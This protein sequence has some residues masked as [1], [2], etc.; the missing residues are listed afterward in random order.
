MLLS[1][2]LTGYSQREL[3]TCNSD[4]TDAYISFEDLKD[5]SNI[6]WLKEQNTLSN[7][8][9]E[10]L[11][12]FTDHLKEKK[13]NN[14]DRYITN[15]SRET[16]TREGHIFYLKSTKENQK[17]LYYI[18]NKGE[19]HIKLVDLNDLPF[20]NKISEGSYLTYY[21][22]SWNGKYVAIAIAFKG[23]ETTTLFVVDVKN[24][25]FINTPIDYVLTGVGGIHWAPDNSGIFYS[26]IN[27]TS[28]GTSENNLDTKIFNYNIREKKETE[29]FSRTNNPVVK[30]QP[31][32]F[33]I[34]TVGHPQDTYLVGQ[35]DNSTPNFD[36]YLLP[37]HEFIKKDKNAWIPFFT[38]EEQIKKYYQKGDS[39]LYLT[40]NET[41]NFE[42][43]GVSLKSPNFKEPTII[44]KENSKE[45]IQDFALTKEGLFYVAKINGVISK[46][47]RKYKGKITEIKLPKSAGTIRINGLGHDQSY[48]SVRLYGWTS[49]K[50]SYIF[51]FK[52]NNLIKEKSIDEQ[53][54]VSTPSF[55][56][57]LI[58]EE[59]EIPSYDGAMVPLSLVYHKDLKKDGTAPVVL[60][61]YGAYGVTWVPSYFY[62]LLMP[63]LEGGVYALAHVRGG[64]SKGRKWYE[65]GFKKTKSNT[66]KDVIACSEYLIKEKYTSKQK[67]ALWGGSAGGIA[68]GMAMVERPELYGAAIFD[69]AVLNPSRF[70]FGINGP[71]FAKE[72]GSVKNPEEKKYLCAMDP[73]NNLKKGTT[74]PP[75]LI[76]VGMN[77]NRV[78]PWQ[79]IKFAA[80]LKD[81][82]SAD[83]PVLLHTD[84]E[85]GHGYNEAQSKRDQRYLNAIVFALENTK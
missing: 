60:E 65:Q 64:G 37:V 85:S 48:L 69:F 50:E 54:P 77:D 7:N 67:I 21:K 57:D 84:F 40:S 2:G 61:A 33:P 49:K 45:V 75:T 5:D 8:Y 34:V 39:L 25:K 74:Y 79:S 83:N 17:V 38:K 63:V 42:I 10:K 58:I 66:W 32:N 14:N 30:M 24:K 80:K 3:V 62:H 16:I 72:F 56:E 44:I 78:S 4:S 43:R 59:I 22:P 9:F 11:K 46:L 70:E 31:E 52:N 12:V 1:F 81:Y 71:D 29:F 27:P 19:K 6:E 76:H 55:L 20:K 53:K 13:K 41:P 73:F 51:D 28:I 18:E 82:N 68:T 35:V 47:Y 26:K 23:K 36:A 15:I